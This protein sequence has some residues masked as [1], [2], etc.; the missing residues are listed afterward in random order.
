MF[1]LLLT[2]IIYLIPQRQVIQWI[3][4]IKNI[5]NN[6]NAN[7]IINSIQHKLNKQNWFQ[8]MNM[9]SWSKQNQYQ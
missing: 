5:D 2:V 1:V 8:M 4:N 3:Y 6:L 9:T 7:T